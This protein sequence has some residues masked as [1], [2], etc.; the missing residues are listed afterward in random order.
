MSTT[1]RASIAIP[2]ADTEVEAFRLAIRSVFAQEEQRWEL[3]LWSDGAPDHLVALAESIDDP[4]VRFRAN[5]EQM[6]LAATLN[7]IAEDA[8]APVLARMDA[9]DVMLPGR[10][11]VTLGHL[12]QHPEVDLIATRALLID[13]RG[14]LQGLLTEAETV[15]DLSRSVLR[16][17]IT[18]PTV[19][20]RTA[21]FRANPYSVEW[22]RTEDKQLWQ[23]AGPRSVVT[24]LAEPTLAYR[25]PRRAVAS[26]ARRTRRE[27]RRLLRAYGPAALGRAECAR[28]WV[29]SLGGSGILALARHLPPLEDRLYQR[30][31]SSL[32]PAAH[33]RA[34]DQLSAVQNTSV[35]GW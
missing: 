18:H 8:V 26:K 12:E 15:G 20:A 28:A 24:K 23:T 1:A 11:R 5:L 30:K 19:V 21:W 17:P 14:A 13:E 4:R 9:D 3:V 34:V 6:G 35:P 25:I 31:S 27:D 7:A 22:A 29:A 16:N 10:L 33:R 2:F 32:D